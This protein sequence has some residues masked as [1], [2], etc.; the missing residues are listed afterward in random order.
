MKA[1]P[2]MILYGHRYSGLCAEL[3]V[4]L[5]FGLTHKESVADMSGLTLAVVRINKDG[6]V[7]MSKPC[8]GCQNLIKQCGFEKV[9]YTLNDGTWE[10]QN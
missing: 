6:S 8:N 5:K 10:E 4:C 7:G 2:R 1:H 9:L 3:D